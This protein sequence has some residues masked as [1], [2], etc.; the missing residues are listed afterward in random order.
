[1][2]PRTGRPLKGDAP[3]NVSIQL[4]ISQKTADELQRCAEMLEI[5]RTEVIEQGIKTIYRQVVK[6]K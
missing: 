3:K 4:R 6:E 2:S 5:S 1:M